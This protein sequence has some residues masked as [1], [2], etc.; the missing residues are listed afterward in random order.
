MM[1]KGSSLAERLRQEQATAEWVVGKDGKRYRKV[2]TII[3]IKAY[4]ALGLPL[5]LI[6]LIMAGLLICPGGE[7]NILELFWTRV[8]GG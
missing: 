6:L 4:L 1:K 8:G 7:K 2:K 3:L 5:L